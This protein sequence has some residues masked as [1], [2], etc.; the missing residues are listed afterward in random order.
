LQW[1]R[2]EDPHGNPFVAI[3]VDPIRSYHYSIPELKAFRAYPP[4]YNSPVENECP[5]GT[6]ET[7]D[8][9]RLELWGSCWNRYYELVRNMKNI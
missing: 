5:D 9:Q 2:A 1:Q 6:V 7:A 8:Q 3:V 4:E